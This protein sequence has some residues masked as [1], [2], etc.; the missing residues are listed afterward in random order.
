[1]TGSRRIC[2]AL[3]SKPPRKTGFM[4]DKAVS[5]KAACAASSGA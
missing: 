2:K 5:K 3:R 1:M 4:T